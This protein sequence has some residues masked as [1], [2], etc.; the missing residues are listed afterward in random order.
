MNASDILLLHGATDDDLML[1]SFDVYVRP[2]DNP[3]WTPRF[4]GRTTREKTLSPAWEYAEWWDGMPQALWATHVTKVEL[5]MKFGFAQL[6]DPVT[7]GFV[8]DTD[9]DDSDATTSVQYFGTNPGSA[10]D[11]T[12]WFIGELVDQREISI[13][14]R[15]ARVTN[16][17]DMEFGTG[18]Y[19]VGN[20]TVRALKDDNTCN[21]ERN[22][23]YICIEKLATPSGGFVDPCASTVTFCEP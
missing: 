12:W 21:T 4:I 5:M 20:V 7:W 1:G 10:P 17:E 9:L 16:P 3:T 8:F 19:T 18:D 14:F 2:Y 11:F 15:R 6:G 22:L 23:A 13:V